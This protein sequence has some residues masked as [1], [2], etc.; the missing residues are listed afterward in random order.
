M[1]FCVLTGPALQSS[2][3]ASICFPASA[4]VE[5][6]SSGLAAEEQAEGRNDHELHVSLRRSL[7]TEAEGQGSSYYTYVS[8]SR[9][10]ADAEKQPEAT[11]PAVAWFRCRQH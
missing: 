11:G 2:S 4:T 9:T 8:E 10:H 1:P 6:R 3:G 7:P 5:S